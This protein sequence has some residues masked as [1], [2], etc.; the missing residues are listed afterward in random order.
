MR[1]L[2]VLVVLISSLLPTLAAQ[3]PETMPAAGAAAKAAEQ[4]K[5]YS[6]ESFVIE[7]VL[8]RF[9]FE[10][11]G[12]GRKETIAR[13]RV[14]SE[15]GVEQ[16]GQVVFGY[17]SANER[18]EIPYVR[19]LKKDGS[20]VTTPADSVQDLSAPV[21]R[22]APVYT[23]YRQKHITVP[24]L[25][26][27]EVL[28]YDLA[29]VIHTPLAPNQFWSEYDFDKNNITLDEQLEVDIPKERTI[30]LK[31]KPGFEPKVSEENG[32]RIYR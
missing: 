7:K 14:Q 6:Q 18:V 16:W 8:T 32:R 21:T 10:T 17:N 1:R 26:P 20:V 2:A 22:E 15:A 3:Q 29:T 24:G 19:V 23:D 4:Q 12:T 11:D 30:K 9:R 28:E 25:R 5:D 27:G 31:N 13:V